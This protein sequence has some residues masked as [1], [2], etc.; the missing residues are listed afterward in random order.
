MEDWERRIAVVV[1]GIPLR[2]PECSPDVPL[3]EWPAGSCGEHEVGRLLEERCELVL[4]EQCGEL[5]GD[6]NGPGRSVRLGWPTLPAPIHLPRE[7]DLRVLQI[8]ELD[9]GPRQAEELGDARTGQRREREKGAPWLLSR[10]NRLFELGALEDPP[11]LR[12]RWLRPLGSQH[13]RYR[14]GARPLEPARRVPVDPIRDADRARDGRLG[15]SL[16]SHVSHESGEI[17]WRDRIEPA[18]AEPRQEIG[19]HGISIGLVRPRAQIAHGTIEPRR[20]GINQSQASL[21]L[22]TLAPATTSKHLITDG[23]RGGD[24]AFHFPP[25][26]LAAAVPEANFVLAVVTAIDVALDAE[27]PRSR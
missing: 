20:R 14:V 15:E 17:V 6:R 27:T 3:P 10:R 18:I 9:V 23:S 1:R 12:P 26:L 2:H 4:P 8:V 21:G 24:A 13:D 16:R 5:S 22:Y 25:P 7:L 11:A 19:I